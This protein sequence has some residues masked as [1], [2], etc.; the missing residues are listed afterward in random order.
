MR[1]IL[2]R[3]RSA[4][5]SSL[6]V[7]SLAPSALAQS[8]RA[9]ASRTADYIIAIV[10]QEL[11]TAGEVQQRIDQVRENA[12]RSGMRLP[13]EDELRRGVLEALI[14]ERAQI[15]NARESGTRVDDAEVERAIANVAA[16]NQLTPAQLRERL[17][18]EG[19]DYARFR[20]NIREQLMMER[21]RER[22]VQARI[23]ISDTE[24]ENWLEAQ[25]TAAGSASE[26]NI[27]Q[28]LVTVPEGATDTVVA[29]RR[30]RAEAALARIRGGE[31][32]DAVA[33]EVS[34]DT[35]RAKGG[36]IGLRPANRLPDVFLDAVRPLKAGQVS[37][38]VL[39]TGAGFHILKLLERNEAGALSITQTRARHI[40]LRISPQW[41]QDAASRRLLEFKRQIAGGA[42]TFEQLARDNSED[43]SAPQGG[44]LGW[45]S[46]GNFVPEFEQA[47]NALPIGG[48]SDPVVSRFGVHL[49]QVVERRKTALDAK[50]QREQ[51]RAALREQ[52][53]ETAYNDWVRDLRDRAY[54]EMREPPP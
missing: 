46:P 17:A 47:M 43:G 37:P 41:T 34:E 13:P 39:R 10:N 20:K 14:S 40:L 52:K 38:A 12:R 44:D 15:T 30:A 54:V 33:R 18:R 42:R 51:A 2:P 27:A 53:F 50:Q 6:L 19:M 23:R 25:R 49:I 35:N 4:L 1:L 28:V 21:T 3:L 9:N 36:E 24:I 32:F 5:L 26:Y 31:A 29:E 8:Q 22:E 45:A 48:I 16:Q 7:A 11:V